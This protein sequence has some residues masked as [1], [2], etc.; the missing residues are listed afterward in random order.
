MSR[1]LAN[2]GRDSV[3]PSVDPSPKQHKKSRGKSIKSFLFNRQKNRQIRSQSSTSS[4]D[5]VL[6]IS[7][8]PLSPENQGQGFFT[9]SSSVSTDATSPSP[10]RDGSLA[11]GVSERGV[12]LPLE[13]VDHRQQ[14]S[15][16]RE[17][18]EREEVEREEVEREGV[19]GEGVS[20]EVEAQSDGARLV[21]T[22]IH[23]S[24]IITCLWFVFLRQ[25][26]FAGK[27]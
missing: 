4:D 2:R 1:R 8:V 26:L 14:S 20:D 7:P 13:E 22:Y 24:S 9:P 21:C 3:S 5:D 19:Q 6:P 17:G 18:V 11:L 12:D 27:L 23:N 10:T 25:F 16:E 15:E